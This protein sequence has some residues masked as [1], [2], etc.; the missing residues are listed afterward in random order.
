MI[1][2]HNI[3]ILSGDLNYRIDMRRD[4]V[5]ERIQSGRF[6]LLWDHDQLVK[7]IRTNP[8]HRLRSFKE[9]ELAFAPTYKYDRFVFV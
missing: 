7:Q 3:V 4:A 9:S 5:I 2:D 8:Q 1:F 6:D